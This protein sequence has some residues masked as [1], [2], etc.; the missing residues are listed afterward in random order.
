MND[1]GGDFNHIFFHF[2]CYTT[3]EV[4]GSHVVIFSYIYWTNDIHI[5]VASMLNTLP[6]HIILLFDY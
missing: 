5:K 3:F 6:Q 1:T 4:S 2:L